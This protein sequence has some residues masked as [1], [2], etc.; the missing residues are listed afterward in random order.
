MANSEPKTSRLETTLA[1]MAAGVVGFSLIDMLVSLLLQLI[2]VRPWA[3]MF[4]IP[5][6]GLPIGFL[7]IVGLL[8]ASISRRSKEN[9]QRR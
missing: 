1:F 6:I 2:N 7:L 5:L 9:R 8:L 4:Q 3:V